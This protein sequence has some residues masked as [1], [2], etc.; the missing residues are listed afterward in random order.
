MPP[1]LQ[2]DC[3]LLAL[4]AAIYHDTLRRHR[5]AGALRMCAIGAQRAN[6]CIV[7]LRVNQFQS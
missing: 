6:D 7:G 3:M 1:R 5:L 4:V 2:C